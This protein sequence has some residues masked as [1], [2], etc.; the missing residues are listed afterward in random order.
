M[1]VFPSQ[2]VPFK[3]VPQFPCLSY[4]CHV[5]PTVL[6]LV[7]WDLYVELNLPI[8]KSVYCSF[9]QGKDHPCPD[10]A[11]IEATFFFLAFTNLCRQGR[12]DS[13]YPGA[14]S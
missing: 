7:S 3:L 13:I 5:S 11:L 4:I 6:I 14:Q 10:Y 2:L 1:C 12:S 9:C 8:S